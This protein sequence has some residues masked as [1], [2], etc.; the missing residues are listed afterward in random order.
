MA[1]SGQS[2]RFADVHR[3]SAKRLIPSVKAD[4]LI[5]QLGA[6]SRHP[7]HRC[8]S[9]DASRRVICLDGHEG[10]QYRSFRDVPGSLFRDCLSRAAKIH[11]SRKRPIVS[12]ARA[13]ADCYPYDGDVPGIRS[14]HCAREAPGS[15]GSAKY[16]VSR[17]TFPS[18]NSMMLTV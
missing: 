13:S 18:R 4:I 11:P 7:R 3:R 9:C 12:S 10:R 2:R 1:A 17:A 6:N 15:N 8:S 16:W 14:T 5:R